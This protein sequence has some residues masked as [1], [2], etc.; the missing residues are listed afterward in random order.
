MGRAAL[1][2]DFPTFQEKVLAMQVKFAD[3]SIQLTTVRGERLSFDWQG[4]FLRNGQEQPLSG[5]MHY[6]N[7]YTQTNYP[8]TQMEI[9][10]G[11]DLMRLDFGSVED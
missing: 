5:F 11:E 9:Q 1:D 4:S 7:P 6:E 10:Y 3:Q 8:C 2:G